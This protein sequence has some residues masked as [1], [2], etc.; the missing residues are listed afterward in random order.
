MELSSLPPEIL[1]GI[2]QRLPGKYIANLW[3]CGDLTLNIK[4]SRGGVTVL[5]CNAE[6]KAAL[7]LLAR[8][9]SLLELY[10]FPPSLIQCSSLTLLTYFIPFFK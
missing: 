3:H 5:V 1:A 6:N 8:F 10:G 7:P 9:H 2:T 4:L